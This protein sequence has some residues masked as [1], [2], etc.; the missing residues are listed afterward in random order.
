MTRRA[1]LAALAGAAVAPTLPVKLTKDEW[2]RSVLAP[3][4]PADITIKLVAAP[5]RMRKDGECFKWPL[6]LLTQA[7]L[8]E[9]L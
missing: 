4:T 7:A 5:A 3:I 8:R 6:R 1:L 9:G 2:I